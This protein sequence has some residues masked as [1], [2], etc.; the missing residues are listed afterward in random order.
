MHVYTDNISYSTQV[1]ESAHGWT[2]TSRLSLQHELQLLVR[3]LLP[4]DELFRAEIESDD[5]WRTLLITEFAHR[6]QF[7]VLLDLS[8]AGASLPSGTVCLAGSGNSFHGFRSRPWAAAPGNLHLSAFLTPNRAIDHFDVGFTILSAVSVVQTIDTLQG[9]AHRAMIRWINDVIIDQAKVSGVLTA[10]QSSRNLVTGAVI[11]VGLNVETRPHVEP[12]P[13]V[14]EAGA[15]WDFVEAKQPSRSHILTR[16][17][18]RL[19]HNYRLL[20]GG[21]YDQLLDFYRGRS[22]VANKRVQIFADTVDGALQELARGRVLSI[23]EGLELILEGVDTP[24]RKGRLVVAQ[25]AS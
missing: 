7:D 12:T 21:R 17:L 10:S 11:G 20:V 2:R 22:L 19:A 18:D 8:R 16:L 9:L 5:C 23:G 6:S 3:S 1:L 4:G 25:A 24:I 13:F 15:L 14:R